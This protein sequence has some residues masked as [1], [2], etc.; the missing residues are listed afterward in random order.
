MAKLNQSIPL[1]ALR[2]NKTE[3][4]RIVDN[5]LKDKCEAKIDKIL[6]TL[7]VK[8]QE[9]TTILARINSLKAIITETE[10]RLS[11]ASQYLSVHDNEALELLHEEIYQQDFSILN[12]I[13]GSKPMYYP[14][15]LRAA[16]PGF[17]HHN[18]DH[19]D[20][21]AQNVK[22]LQEAGGK[23]H[24]YW[25]VKFRRRKNQNG[26][27]HVKI[28]IT[29][30]KKFYVEIENARKEALQC[31]IL[32]RHY[33]EDLIRLQKMDGPRI[34]ESLLEDLNVHRYLLAQVSTSKLDFKIFE[35]LVESKVYVRDL[36]QSSVNIEK[37]LL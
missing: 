9:Q 24:S 29:R 31:R 13:E 23:G 34:L 37:F 18:L 22:I 5:I 8:D 4:M 1:Q 12:I 3:K 36:V 27:F 10:D 33:E 21:R 6:K 20:I 2:M 35:M 7:G 32:L 26:L 19:I 25:A 14:G 11:R 15:K 17:V 16:T 28:Y 30:K